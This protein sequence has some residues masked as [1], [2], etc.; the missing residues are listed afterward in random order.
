MKA[1][2]NPTIIELVREGNFNMEELKEKLISTIEAELEHRPVK[3]ETKFEIDVQSIG[4]KVIVYVKLA[5]K[6]CTYELYINI[7]SSLQ[8]DFDEEELAIYIGRMHTQ[9]SSIGALAINMADRLNYWYPGSTVEYDYSFLEIT[10][11]VKPMK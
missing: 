4:S 1:K 9:I 11:E 7:G 2:K 6:I 8:D 3:Y 5:N 10:G